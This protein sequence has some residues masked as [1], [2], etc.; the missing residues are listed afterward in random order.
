MPQDR[1]GDLDLRAGGT[2]LHGVNISPSLRPD[3]LNSYIFIKDRGTS[4]T[5]WNYVVLRGKE[6]EVFAQRQRLPDRSLG[7]RSDWYPRRVGKQ[8]IIAKGQ[9]RTAYVLLTDSEVS[10][11]K[12]RTIE[13]YAVQSEYMAST[14]NV[15]TVLT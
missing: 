9:A 15:L 5:T 1:H 4:S 11:H 10:R 3:V 8:V 6:L 2:F 7:F 12:L 14:L 13:T